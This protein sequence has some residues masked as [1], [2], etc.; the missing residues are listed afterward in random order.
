MTSGPKALVAVADG[1]LVSPAARSRSCTVCATASGIA[2]LTVPVA[3]PKGVAKDW[4]PVGQDQVAACACIDSSW[5]LSA[6]LGFPSRPPNHGQLEEFFRSSKPGTYF[7]HD[8]ADAA[9]DL[10]GFC[11]R[12]VDAVHPAA[13]QRPEPALVASAGDSVVVGGLLAPVVVKSR[14]GSAR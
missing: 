7:H 14:P 4:L 11:R 9:A 12:S 3:K 10:P 6:A 1:G 8:P 13:D 2:C 5:N